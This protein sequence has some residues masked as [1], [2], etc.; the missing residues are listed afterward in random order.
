[1]T[2]NQ[3]QNQGVSII[4][5]IIAG[6]FLLIFSVVFIIEMADLS[7]ASGGL[8]DEDVTADSYMDIVQPLMVNA[9]AELAPDLLERFTCNSCHTHGLAPAYD[10]IRVN[11]ADRRAPMQA[12]AYI[13]ES[14]IYPGAYRVEGEMNNMPRD[15]EGRISD[16]ELGHLIAYLSGEEG[17]PPIVEST[18]EPEITQEPLTEDSYVDIVEFLLA[19]AD[20]SRGE[21]LVES[22]GCNV[23]HAGDAAG[24]VAPPH[25]EVAELAAERR[26]PLTA[27]AYIYESIIHP[28]YF[29]VEGY[30]A[31]M[32]QNYEELISVTDLGDIIA[33]L[34]GEN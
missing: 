18:P 28:N 11:A 2:E 29:V 9:D 32:P 13:Y 22:Y 3:E 8:K 12:Q 15:F 30:T 6:V 23:C 7:K 27:A 4:P 17:A 19:S 10:V 20:A 33:Y 5:I 26:P 16:E 1:M 24:V 34:L 31:S 25:A 21:D 14:I